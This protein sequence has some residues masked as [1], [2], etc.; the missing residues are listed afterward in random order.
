MTEKKNPVPKNFQKDNIIS[1]P[2]GKK[3]NEI[4][5]I[6]QTETGAIGTG[7]RKVTPKTTEAPKPK[8]DNRVAIHS[9]K[10]VYLPGVG[11]VLRGYNIVK[12]EAAEKW[13][14]RDHIREATPEE[15]A[16]EYGL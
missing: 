8:E 7:T 4:K 5:V 10:N 2:K 9:T 15:I 1:G 6:A 16:R 12:R 14:A 11:K 13:L 3:K